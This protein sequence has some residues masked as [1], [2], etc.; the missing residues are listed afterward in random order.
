LSRKDIFPKSADHADIAAEP[1][2]SHGLI[3]ALTA[4]IGRE[5]SSGYCLARTR[6]SLD[7]SHKIEVDAAYDDN[8]FGHR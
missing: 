8:S 2:S 1:R 3:C 5:T 4:R 6:H 7:G